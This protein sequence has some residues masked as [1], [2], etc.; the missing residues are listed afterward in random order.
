MQW[1]DSFLF[2]HHL[3]LAKYSWTFCLS[4]PP[5]YPLCHMLTGCSVSQSKAV[6]SGEVEVEGS[7]SPNYPNGRK[8]FSEA[9]ALDSK[10]YRDQLHLTS[11][12]IH[13]DKQCYS[14]SALFQFTVLLW[15]R[16]SENMSKLA[17]RL[18]KQH[19]RQLRTPNLLNNSLRVVAWGFC[20]PHVGHHGLPLHFT[21]CT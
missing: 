12:V 10:L 15:M 9:T 6:W 5:C 17:V 14:N 2:M 13:K 1:K 4:I 20:G 11:L 19:K 8:Y 18:W 7:S 3:F 16:A 21:H